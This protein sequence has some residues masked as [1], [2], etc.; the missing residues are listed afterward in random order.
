VFDEAGHYDYS[1][2]DGEDVEQRVSIDGDL[3]NCDPHFEEILKRITLSL[4]ERERRCLRMRYDNKTLEEI[5][6]AVGL[7]TPSGVSE[8]VRKAGE[9][10]VREIRATGYSVNTDY[11]TILGI[12]MRFC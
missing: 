9:K 5:A 6:I 8:T 11:E 4:S 12:I 3:A 2:G 7:K 10:I 1:E